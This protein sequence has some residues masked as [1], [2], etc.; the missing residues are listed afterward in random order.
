[1]RILGVR[2][3]LTR[4]EA[5]GER[6]EQAEE[7]VLL[8][9]GALIAGEAK[10]NVRGGGSRLNVR[11]GRLSRSLTAVRIGRG[12]VAVGTNVIYAP[13]HEFGATITAKN[14][15]YLRFQYPRRSGQW[16]SV[17]SVTIPAR[18]FLGPALASKRDEAVGLIRKFYTG[19]LRLGG[20]LLG[21][22]RA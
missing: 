11:T 10:R 7:K 2:S 6:A 15:P 22:T 12:R 3:L 19:P 14:A 4:L 17:R 9:A 13:V 1:M 5:I 21:G 16:H 20:T 18:P 8:D